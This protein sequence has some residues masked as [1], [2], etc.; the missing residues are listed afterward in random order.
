[1]NLGTFAYACLRLSFFL[2]KKLHNGVTGRRRFEGTFI[3]CFNCKFVLEEWIFQ[4][5]VSLEDDKNIIHR[6]ADIRLS[7]NTK[8]H[9][10][11][12]WYPLIFKYKISS[13]DTLISAYLQIQNK[14]ASKITNHCTV[15][16]VIK[17][18]SAD[19]F[20]KIKG[21]ISQHKHL[22]STTQ[23]V[24]PTFG[25]MFLYINYCSHKFRLQL[26]SILRKLISFLDVRS[27]SSACVAQIPHVGLKS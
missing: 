1:M 25:T 13:F 10:S 23:Y 15:Q 4:H 16:T 8:Y 27:W 26:L 9:P 18:W 11:T 2:N 14:N 7:S 20:D 24:A 12:R 6:H 5:L 21:V 17:L 19:I 22:L 3:L